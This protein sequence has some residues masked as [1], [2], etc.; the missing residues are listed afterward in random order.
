MHASNKF[1]LSITDLKQDPFLIY[2]YIHRSRSIIV[3]NSSS[4]QYWFVEICSLH[5]VQF[6]P[7]LYGSTDKQLKDVKD[8]R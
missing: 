2:I 7:F 4:N 6:L 3:L 5:M 8:I 1:S